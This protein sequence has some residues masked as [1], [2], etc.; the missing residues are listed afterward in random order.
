M[1]VALLSPGEEE[2]VTIFLNS[3]KYFEIDNYYHPRR[4][5]SAVAPL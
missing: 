3:G 2:D 1:I 5:Q 4:L